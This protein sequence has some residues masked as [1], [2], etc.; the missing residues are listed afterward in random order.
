MSDG[1]MSPLA[2]VQED[3]MS[4]IRQIFDRA[5]NA[6]VQAS[7]LSKQVADLQSQFQALK[8]DMEYLRKRN[9]ELDV[10]LADVRGQRDQA[11]RERD[12]AK[13]NHAA[14][15]NKAG[16][17]Q[18]K[19]DYANRLNEAL[20]SELTSTKADRDQA[21]DAWHKAETA[22]D[23]AEG[24]LRDIEDFAQR[25]FGLSRLQPIPAPQPVAEPIQ[26]VTHEEPVPLAPQSEPDRPSAQDY[27]GRTW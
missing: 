9:A 27:P 17:L 8:N 5:A 18:A 22:K 19:L 21:Y 25:A 14:E 15:Q 6:I 13:N 3:E 1:T 20:Q 26:A 4:H 10:A 2:P 12:E 23:E 24:K 16:D 11:M 7:E